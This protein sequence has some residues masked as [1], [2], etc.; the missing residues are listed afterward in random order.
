MIVVISEEE[1][2]E[3]EV[4]GIPIRKDPMTGVITAEIQRF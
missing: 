2:A 3:M 1:A 4:N